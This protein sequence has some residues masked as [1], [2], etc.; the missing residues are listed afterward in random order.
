MRLFSHTSAGELAMMSKELSR[1]LRNLSLDPGL[2]EA[3]ESNPETILSDTE[4]SE[5]EKR[6]LRGTDREELRR[7]LAAGAA[8]D[9]NL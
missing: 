8:P 7:E 2:L 3:F 1:F 9:P 6:T 4:L 5:E